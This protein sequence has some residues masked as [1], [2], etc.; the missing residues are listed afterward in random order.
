MYGNACIYIHI[1]YMYIFI[2]TYIQIYIYMCIYNIYIYTFIS[3]N[4]LFSGLL[5]ISRVILKK[6]GFYHFPHNDHLS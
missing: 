4:L 3:F 1:I 2:F 5:K 6:V